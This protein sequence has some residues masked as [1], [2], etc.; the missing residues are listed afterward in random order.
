MTTKASM[1]SYVIVFDELFWL[2][3]PFANYTSREKK[4]GLPGGAVS[5]RLHTS[6]GAALSG[7]FAF[8]G[9]A[10]SYPLLFGGCSLK[11]LHLGFAALTA[12]HNFALW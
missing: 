5:F 11:P 8:W 6:R 12:L 10:P 2:G 1:R 4:S 7:C 9:V 3:E